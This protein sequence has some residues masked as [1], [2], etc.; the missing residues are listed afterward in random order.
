MFIKLP[1]GTVLSI[2]S[3]FPIPSIHRLQLASKYF[4]NLITR[5]ESIVYCFAAFQHGFI[6][7]NAI[8]IDQLDTLPTGKKVLAEMKRAWKVLCQ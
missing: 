1:A 3:Y 5:N 8:K 6:P 4:R 2:L 7:F